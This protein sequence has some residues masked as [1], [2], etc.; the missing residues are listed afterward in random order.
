M[1]GAEA[2]FECECNNAVNLSISGLDMGVL[3][4]PENTVQGVPLWPKIPMRA[5]PLPTYSIMG[6][7][8]A[9]TGTR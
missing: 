8:L 6:V 3:R 2:T 7:P 5:D 4:L 1:D 9:P